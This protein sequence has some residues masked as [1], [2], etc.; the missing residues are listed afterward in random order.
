M[1]KPVKK[2][3]D[4][5]QAAFN[6]VSRIAEMGS[7]TVPPAGLSDY[8]ARIGSKGGKIG[9]KR[10]LQTMTPE[11]RSELALKAARARWKKKTAKSR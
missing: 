3:M 8:M 10:R 1:P 4:A 9:G 5:N 6:A 11:Q 7:D 2:Q